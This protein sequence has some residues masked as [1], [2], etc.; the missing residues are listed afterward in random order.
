MALRHEPSARQSSTVD[1]TRPFHS[2]R[3][4]PW[5][6][7]VMGIYQQRSTPCRQETVVDTYSRKRHQNPSHAVTGLTKS[8]TSPGVG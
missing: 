2:L 5:S 6:V 1:E 7:S 3:I 8:T 4:G